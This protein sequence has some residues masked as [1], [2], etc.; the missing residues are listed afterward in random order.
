LTLKRGY[1][2]KAHL[3]SYDKDSRDP[4]PN[5]K[6]RGFDSYLKY[7]LA[8]KLYYSISSNYYGDRILEGLQ[9]K[10]SSIIVRS[11]NDTFKICKSLFK[12][13]N[14][15]VLEEFLVMTNQS[16]SECIESN[17]TTIDGINSKKPINLDVAQ[18]LIEQCQKLGINKEQ[19]LHLIE[20]VYK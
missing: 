11:D 17:C 4:Q 6:Q 13:S 2:L 10:F 8:Q 14:R 9:K 19:M 12:I 1:Y 5:I 15:S 3:L 18:N 20:T 16:L 7:K